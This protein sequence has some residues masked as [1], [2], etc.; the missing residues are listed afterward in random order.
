M[1][2]C[3]LIDLCGVRS[4]KNKPMFG[5]RRAAGVEMFSVVSWCPQSLCSVPQPKLVVGRGSGLIKRRRLYGEM[6]HF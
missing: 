4:D 3:L 2:L 1:P 6:A 5:Q